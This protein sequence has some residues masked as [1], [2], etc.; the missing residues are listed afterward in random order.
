M[1]T[2]VVVVF[3]AFTVPVLTMLPAGWHTLFLTGQVLS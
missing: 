3:W 1:T 2:V